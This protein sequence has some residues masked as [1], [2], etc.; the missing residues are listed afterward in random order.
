MWIHSTSV[1][2]RGDEGLVWHFESCVFLLWLGTRNNNKI[3]LINAWV[4]MMVQV[5]SHFTLSSVK[6][7]YTF[8]LRFYG[9]QASLRL[10]NQQQ[11]MLVSN[12]TGHQM[13]TFTE[14]IISCYIKELL[15]RSPLLRLASTMLA[16][17]NLYPVRQAN[18]V[19]AASSGTTETS[20]ST[21]PM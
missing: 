19:L 17:S 9:N 7:C 16:V 4:T 2:K 1:R 8:L 3:L 6:D 14:S 18:F 12:V 11:P 20:K 21:L 15:I 13:L 10:I 5:K